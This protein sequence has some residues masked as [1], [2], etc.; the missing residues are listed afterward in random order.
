M[1]HL[2]FL[3][4]LRHLYCL[5]KASHSEGLQRQV[6]IEHFHTMCLTVQKK[7]KTEEAPNTD[8]SECESKCSSVDENQFPVCEPQCSNGGNK[9]PVVNLSGCHKLH[10]QFQP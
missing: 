9:F 5:L 4:F 7:V 3:Y 10:N 1:L 8:S 6:L 2:I